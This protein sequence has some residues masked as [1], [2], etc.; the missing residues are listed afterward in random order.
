M[1]S[2]AQKAEFQQQ[3]IAQY[4]AELFQLHEK[5]EEIEAAKAICE[6]RLAAMKSTVEKAK[7]KR[8]VKDDS[9]PADCE[10]VQSQ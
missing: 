5:I 4:E 1:I 3:K 7:G 10:P 8:K 6:K 9:T 2:S